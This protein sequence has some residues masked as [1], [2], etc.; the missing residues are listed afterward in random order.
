VVELARSTLESFDVMTE[1]DW[2]AVEFRI[3]AT[4]N[5]R[6]V[7][8]NRSAFLT[9]KDDKVHVIDLYCPEPIPAPAQELDRAADLSDENCGG[10]L[11]A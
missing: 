6:Y 5:Q 4:E 2:G 11:K 9:I 3:Q 1:G 7:E 10:C 8:H